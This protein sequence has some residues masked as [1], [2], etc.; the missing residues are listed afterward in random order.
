MS[1]KATMHWRNFSSGRVNMVPQ[2]LTR[3]KGS[4]EIEKSSE[5]ESGR[6][7]CSEPPKEGTRVTERRQWA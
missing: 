1:V 5:L 4:F 6:I 2:T 7:L 3:G